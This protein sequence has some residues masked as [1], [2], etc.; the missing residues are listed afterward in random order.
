[1]RHLQLF[2]SVGDWNVVDTIMENATCGKWNFNDER[3][4]YTED[5]Q[6]ILYSK[7]FWKLVFKLAHAQTVCT[8]RFS[9]PFSN[10]WVRGYLTQRAVTMVHIGVTTPNTYRPPPSE[11]FI[12]G[13]LTRLSSPCESS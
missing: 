6:N 10:A 4:C 5:Y 9:S 7:D 13:Q 12:Y 11:Q 1:M 2:E 8:R 3:H